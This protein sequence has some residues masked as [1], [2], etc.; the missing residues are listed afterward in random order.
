MHIS[1]LWHWVT[2]LSCD[3]L[4]RLPEEVKFSGVETLKIFG[5]MLRKVWNMSSSIAWWEERKFRSQL[6]QTIGSVSGCLWRHA[7]SEKESHEVWKWRLQ[8]VSGIG[9]AVHFYIIFILKLDH[10]TNISTDSD[11]CAF[12]PK[13]VGKL[14]KNTISRNHKITNKRRLLLCAKELAQNAPLWSRVANHYCCRYYTLDHSQGFDF[15]P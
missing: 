2:Q 13:I 9:M 12:A 14:P 15:Q 4:V 7:S 8:R 11:C 3:G 10:K 1:L 6:W 5:S